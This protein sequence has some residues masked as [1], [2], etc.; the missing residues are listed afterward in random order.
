MLT[1]LPDHVRE[2]FLLS[3]LDGMRYKD[4]AAKLNVTERTVKRYMALAF[5]HCLTFAV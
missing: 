3:Q 2:T 1:T 4:I 5:T